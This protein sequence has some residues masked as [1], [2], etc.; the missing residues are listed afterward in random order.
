MLETWDRDIPGLTDEQLADRH[1][2]A[3]DRERS[4]DAPGT[5]RNAKARRDWLRRRQ[6]I[7]EEIAR[8]QFDADEGLHG[9]E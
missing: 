2:L 3:L 6:A 5:G 4:S 8:R 7:E 9:A 1:Q